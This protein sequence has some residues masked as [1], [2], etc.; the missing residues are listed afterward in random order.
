MKIS[1]LPGWGLGVA[2]LLPLADSLSHA[3][4]VQ[5]LPLPECESLEQALDVLDTQIPADSWLA[6]WSL[7]GMLATA[8]AHRRGR[9]C[10][11][12]I[13]LGSNACFVARADWPQAMPE[14]D[15][16]NFSRRAARDW[17]GTLGRFELLCL[18]G[19][20]V[21]AA[22]SM[23]RVTAKPAQV[24]SL[25]WLAQLDNRIAITELQCP[26]LHLLA[27]QDALVPVAVADAVRRLNPQAQVD[28]LSGSHAFILTRHQTVADHLLAWMAGSNHEPC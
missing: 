11:G 1:L 15:F 20:D 6:G 10:P 4:E 27:E 28:V 23:D 12:L 17:A 18:Q 24:A 9:G 2:P 13:T 5:V 21:A 8:L 7:G 16:K 19:E 3:H 14:R 22:V 26:Q 25:A